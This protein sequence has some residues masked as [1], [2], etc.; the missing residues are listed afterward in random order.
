MIAQGECIP[1]IISQV[2]RGAK[3][4]TH[5]LILQKEVLNEVMK[6]LW[7]IPLNVFCPAKVTTHAH[8]IVKRVLNC[9]DPYKG[10]KEDYQQKAWELF[11]YLE[12]LIEDTKDPFMTCVKLAIA[13]NSI[14]FG[15]GDSFNLEKIV[16]NMMNKELPIFEYENFRNDL[17]SAEKVLYIAD[18]AGEFVFDWLFIKEL[19][20]KEIKLVVKNRPILNDITY[21]EVKHLELRNLEIVSGSNA[22]GFPFDEVEERLKKL[23]FSS[24]I[25]ISKGQGNFETLMEIKAPIYFLFQTKCK[26]IADILKVNL[27]DAILL[28]QKLK[29]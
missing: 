1:C 19:H 23:F 16:D 27:G 25:I 13:G 18:N 2:L 4:V 29:Q 28:K 9:Y 3:L 22:I 17:N 15:I 21:N 14:D 6:Y 5:N 8:N 20:D 12:H 10:V 7:S 26:L 24:D 11:P